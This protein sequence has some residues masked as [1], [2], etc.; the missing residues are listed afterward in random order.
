VLLINGNGSGNGSK[1]LGSAQRRRAGAILQH[2]SLLLG[3]SRF[4]PELAGWLDL[5]GIAI[6][7]QALIDALTVRITASLDLRAI[8]APFPAELQSIA[9]T[10]ANNKYGSLTW[11]KRR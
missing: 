8:A 7:A 10:F 3:R 1:I 4:A 5:T 6:S 11:T 2:G 9:A